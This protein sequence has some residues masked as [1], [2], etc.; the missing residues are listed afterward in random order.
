[1]HSN[2]VYRWVAILA[3]A[4][5]LAAVPVRAAL[6]PGTTAPAFFVHPLDGAPLTPAALKGHVVVLNFWEPR[7]SGCTVEAPFLQ[8]IHEQY[9]LKGVMVL[10]VAE[11]EQQEADLRGFVKQ[12]HTS[13][14]VAA[15]GGKVIGRRYRITEHPT[16]Y[17][18]DRAGKIRFVQVG[19]AKG[20]DKKIEDA[21]QAVLEGQKSA[22]AGVRSTALE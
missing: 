15:D 11:L 5:G 1:M 9:A 2:S 7:C 17:I 4:S 19:F 6:N 20:D 3:A 8:R 13:Y 14:L 21:L 10:G 12:F 16:T 18:I 22:S